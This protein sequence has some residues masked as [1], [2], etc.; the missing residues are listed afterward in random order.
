MADV[1]G[2][3]A[4]PESAGGFQHHVSVAYV[5]RDQGPDAAGEAIETVENP[6]R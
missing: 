4:V 2:T 3:G 6:G 5:N 1:L